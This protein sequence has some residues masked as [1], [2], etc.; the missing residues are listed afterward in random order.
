M[1]EAI[2]FTPAHVPEANQ[3]AVVPIYM[4]HHQGMIMLTLVN[5]L[6][7]Q[8]MIHRFHADSRIQTVELLLWEAS[9]DVPSGKRQR[10]RKKRSESDHQSSHLPARIARF[11]KL[12]GTS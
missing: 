7:K 9:I 3:G 2:D 8:I 6:K 4:T 5:C 12:G 1:Y 11:Q 10:Q